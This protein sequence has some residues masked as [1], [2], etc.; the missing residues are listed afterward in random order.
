MQRFHRTALLAVLALALEGCG[1]V[2]R[3]LLYSPNFSN[4]FPCPEAQAAGAT[5]VNDKGLRYIYARVKYPKALLLFFHGVGNGACERAEIIQPLLEMGCDVALVEYPGYSGDHENPSQEL[6]LKNSLAVRDQL[7]GANP[8][9]PL[10]LYGES[11]GTGVASYVAHMRGADALVLQ[12]PYPSIEDVGASTYWFLPVRTIMTE[13]YPAKDWAKDIA[14]PILVFYAADDWVI[15]AKFCEEQ[16]KNFKGPV[17]VECLTDAGH[18]NM[19]QRQ[20]KRYYD[21][22]ER[23]VN[24]VALCQ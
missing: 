20:K 13:K 11:L 18:N 2:S 21:A 4:F 8:G 7:A 14:A 23:F 10:F 24:Q 6:I 16:I 1:G 15:P 3:F 9:L 19:R 17:T 22:L 12:S 5:F